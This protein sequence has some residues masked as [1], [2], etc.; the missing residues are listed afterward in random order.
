MSI[1]VIEGMSGQR[2][3]QIAVIYSENLES[4]VEK[5]DLKL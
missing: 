2:G 5:K 3:V 4:K 1:N